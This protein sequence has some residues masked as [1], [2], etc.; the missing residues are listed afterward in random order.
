[1][2]DL[3]GGD[4]SESPLLEKQVL[5]LVEQQQGTENFNAVVPTSQEVDLSFLDLSTVPPS[6][7]ELTAIIVP[8]EE[9]EEASM[10]SSPVCK[11]SSIAPRMLYQKKSEPLR[12]GE[13]PASS[14]TSSCVSPGSGSA[15]H[16]KTLSN[17]LEWA[18]RCKRRR[19]HLPAH[20][21]EE[22]AKK[23][24][25]AKL[26]LTLTTQQELEA[27]AKRD[28]ELF[29]I[30]KEKKELERELLRLQVIKLKKELNVD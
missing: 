28:E 21:E 26:K 1:M 7:S 24:L 11:W 23:L 5:E 17:E 12:T 10:S 6:P 22:T 9:S 27:K 29:Q 15:L 30:D 19:P 20:E 14:R 4:A 16:N 2:P 3:F 25:D 8:Q 13:L 18:K